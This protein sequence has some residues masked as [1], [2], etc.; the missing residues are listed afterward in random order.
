MRNIFQN[1][2]SCLIVEL[3][4]HTW[5]QANTTSST[6]SGTKLADTDNVAGKFTIV[7][8]IMLDSQIVKWL[9]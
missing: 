7:T 5:N 6:S 3:S 4:G 2:V 8:E 1:D 9:I